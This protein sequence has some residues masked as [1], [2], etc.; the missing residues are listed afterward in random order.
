MNNVTRDMRS[1]NTDEKKCLTYNKGT[2]EVGHMSIF[3]CF[4]VKYCKKLWKTTRLM[5]ICTLSL[6]MDEVSLFAIYRPKL[7][8][9][10]N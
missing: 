1:S 9:P 6:R 5:R 3:K 7:C 2:I 8:P 4:V 10:K